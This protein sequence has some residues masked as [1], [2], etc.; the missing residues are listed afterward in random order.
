MN[1]EDLANIMNSYKE[2]CCDHIDMITDKTI[3]RHP[4]ASNILGTFRD[5]VEEILA[6][7][8]KEALK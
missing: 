8:L 7:E 6:E 2:K 4:E 5:I 3:R 1:S